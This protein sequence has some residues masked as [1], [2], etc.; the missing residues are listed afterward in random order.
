MAILAWT[1][2]SIGG[3]CAVVGII[4]AT[5]V[6]PFLTKLPAAFTPMLWLTLG[7]VLLLASIA[8]AVSGQSYD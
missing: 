2:G 3:L 4:M 6:A 5:E 8:A 1:F 7:V